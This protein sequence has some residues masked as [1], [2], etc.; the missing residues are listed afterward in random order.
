M[1]SL[2]AVLLEARVL[3]ARS[4]NDFSWS[5]WRDR[6]AALAELDHLIAEVRAGRP[7]ASTLDVLFAP[8]GPIQEVSLSSGWAQ[9]YLNIAERYDAA[10]ANAAPST[11]GPGGGP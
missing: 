10:V 7:P 9:E 3:L 5:S 11:R 4:D 8:T 1:V 2:E 6:A